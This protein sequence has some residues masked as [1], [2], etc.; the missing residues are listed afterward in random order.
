MTLFSGPAMN[1]NTPVSQDGCLIELLSD[2]LAKNLTNREN[3]LL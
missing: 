3:T 1:K 2:M